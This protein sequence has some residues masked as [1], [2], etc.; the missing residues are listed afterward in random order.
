MEHIVK[1][2]ISCGVMVCL[3]TAGIAPSMGDTLAPPSIFQKQKLTAEQG[4]GVSV[5]GDQRSP[6]RRLANTA[7]RIAVLTMFMIGGPFV[8]A[9]VGGEISD[10]IRQATTINFPPSML[11]PLTLG[12]IG[13]F[14][15]YSALSA[16][17]CAV[18]NGIS[19]LVRLDDYPSAG[20]EAMAIFIFGTIGAM[21]GAIPTGFLMR[22]AEAVF[23]GML[24]GG[25][26]ATVAFTAY[27]WRAGEASD[28]YRFFADKVRSAAEQWRRLTDLISAE[29]FEPWFSGEQLRYMQLAFNGDIDRAIEAAYRSGT[30]YAAAADG[31]IMQ[32]TGA[33]DAFVGR[34]DDIRRNDVTALYRDRMIGMV[35]QLMQRTD[36]PAELK[37]LMQP[38]ENDLSKTKIYGFYSVVKGPDDF[39]L[40]WHRKGMGEMFVSED[41]IAELQERGPP[42]LLDEY[43]MHELLCPVLGHYGA[44]MVQQRVFPS[45][46]GMAGRIEDKG[47]LG[48][49]LRELIDNAIDSGAA[50]IQ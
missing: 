16:L 30:S 36:I 18:V 5:N 4:S 25:T 10:A 28:L 3:L 26:S 22:S 40:S 50:E 43:L 21:F 1:C 29:S 8:R 45:H 11:V 44:I 34:L 27:F 41:L 46:Y 19:R 17:F 13:V 33:R 12:L 48:R 15:G 7:G 6:V 38:Y 37:R 32:G 49:A 47:V 20:E 2:V 31:Y 42:S 35:R 24:L 9:A 39:V 14:A 23:A